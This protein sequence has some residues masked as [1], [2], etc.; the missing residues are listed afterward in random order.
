MTATTPASTGSIMGTNSYT[1][2]IFRLTSN[3]TL[4][5]W[6]VQLEKAS[7]ASPFQTAT[8]TKQGELAACQR[9]YYR[10][11]P[12]AVNKNFGVCTNTNTTIAIVTGQYPV[13]MRT[14]PSALEQTGTANQY[15]VNVANTVTVCS[16]VPVY[17]GTTSDIIYS[18][19]FT[20]ASGLTTG[21]AGRGIT[22]PTNGA[23]AYLGWSAEL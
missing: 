10:T 15:S 21:Q 20:V 13:T 7:T 9:Y 8:G 2:V 4:D 12:G 1:E 3:A 18:V 22:D 5:I 14:T 11:T 19:T 6:G 23:T 16:S 17:G